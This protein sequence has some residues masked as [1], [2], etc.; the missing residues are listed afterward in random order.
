MRKGFTLIELLIVVIVIGI[1]ATVA[2][3]QYLVAT[4]RAKA[5]KGKHAVALIAQAEKLYRADNGTYINVNAGGANAALGSY[6]E[7]SDVDADSDWSYTVSG[8]GT[9]VFVATGTRKSPSSNA[10]ETI[11]LNQLGTWGGDFTP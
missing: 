7:L 9:S 11:T 1:L 4:E 2:V 3:P 8:A 6:V 5:A 10:G